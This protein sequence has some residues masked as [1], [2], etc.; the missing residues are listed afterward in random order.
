LASEEIP[1][2]G[3]SV[4]L[5]IVIVWPDREAKAVR[6][7]HAETGTMFRVD[8]LAGGRPLTI[9]DVTPPA[10]P[11][12][13][14]QGH[15]FDSLTQA[16]CEFIDNAVANFAANPDVAERT[17]LITIADE[18]SDLRFHVEDTGTGIAD[19]GVAM[20]FADTSAAEGEPSEHGVGLKHALA[21]LNPTNDSWKIAT[22]TAQDLAS[23][24]FRVIQS[25]YQ[26]A[27]A[28]ES[29]PGSEWPGSRTVTGTVVEFRCTQETFATVTRGVPGPVQHFQ[30]KLDYLAEDLSYFYSGL[31]RRGQLVLTILV[32]GAPPRFIGA[33]EPLVVSTIDPPGEN[34]ITASWNP[35]LKLDYRFVTVRAHP[36]TRRR[37]KAT[38]STSGV[39]LRLNGRVI[40]DNIFSEVWLREKHNSY[41]HFLAIIDLVSESKEHRPKTLSTKNGFQRSDPDFTRL[42]QWIRDVCP[43]PPKELR[44]STDENELR[45]E[46]QRVLSAS[47][48]SPDRRAD[49]EVPVYV[50]HSTDPPRVDL[51]F[52]DG[53]LRVLAECKVGSTKLLDFFQLLMEWEGDVADGNHPD[54]AWLIS[55]SHRDQIHSVID[56]WNGRQDQR[57]KNYVFRLR[58][59]SEWFPTRATSGDSEP[60]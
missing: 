25:P 31:I 9:F 42:L 3:K 33:L 37:Y 21:Y 19:F 34:Q 26:F 16:V 17:V 1:R 40:E 53:S 29:R 7:S 56:L 30:T 11:F 35:A 47:A 41:N 52:F 32:Q 55:D 5:A 12:W 54:E 50:T 10:S 6:K 58:R 60:A 36:E 23:D 14:T 28:D 2:R 8:D 43:E 18:G 22:R 48:S 4:D 49:P 15:H 39:Q 45:D 24:S 46:L 44:A 27:M 38:M 59:W 51:V 57:G 20:R 13:R